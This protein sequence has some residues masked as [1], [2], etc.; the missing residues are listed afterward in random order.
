MVEMNESIKVLG[1]SISGE[2]ASGRPERSRAEVVLC[3][4]M[5]P[6]IDGIEATRRMLE[7]YPPFRAIIL[8]SFCECYVIPALQAGAAGL[9]LNAALSATSRVLLSAMSVPVIGLYPSLVLES[10]TTVAP[11]GLV[12]S[13]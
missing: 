6:G 3:D 12:R 13:G 5:L 7:R 8:I 1:E 4:M 2:D 9:L 11:A 10:S